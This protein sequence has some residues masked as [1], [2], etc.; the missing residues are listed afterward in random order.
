M[1][2]SEREVQDHLTDAVLDELPLL[3]GGIGELAQENGP[4]QDAQA[5]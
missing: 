3:V 2:V 4:G 1:V 5:A